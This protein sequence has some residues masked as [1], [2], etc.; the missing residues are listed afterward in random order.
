MLSATWMSQ[1]DMS[2]MALPWHW[3]A[4]SH[5]TKLEKTHHLSSW[6]FLRA[7]TSSSLLIMS[8][9]P[10]LMNMLVMSPCCPYLIPRVDQS[11]CRVT[12][13]IVATRCASGRRMKCNIQQPDDIK[14]WSVVGNSQSSM[15]STIDAEIGH[16]H[17][18]ESSRVSK[19]WQGY[20]NFMRLSPPCIVEGISVDEPW[21][22]NQRWCTSWEYQV[23]KDDS[24]AKRPARRVGYYWALES[25]LLRSL[26][27][28]ASLDQTKS[29]T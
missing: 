10:T 7:N 11:W 29:T 12:W 13:R 26:K 16:A 3:P 15:K 4:I 5:M 2:S 1:V 20:T 24:G 9:C 19:S 8:L 6:I 17:D 25:V 14:Q 27:M 23:S 28:P 22:M 21:S 18:H